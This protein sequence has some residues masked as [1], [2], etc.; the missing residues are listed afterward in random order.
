[1]RYVNLLLKQLHQ[2]SS[3][4]GSGV[5]KKALNIEAWY[6]YATFDLVGDLVFGQSFGCLEGS[7]YH[8][9]GMYEGGEKISVFD[10]TPPRR[11]LLLE[12][13][14]NPKFLFCSVAVANLLVVRTRLFFFVMSLDMFYGLRWFSKVSLGFKV[15]HADMQVDLFHLQVGALGRMARLPLLR[16][17]QRGRPVDMEVQ[18]FPPL[19]EDAGLHQRDAGVAPQLG[20]GAP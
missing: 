4:S 10:E 19:R 18:Q 13:C 20:Q 8:P 11:L 9:W 16:R 12:A 14:R 17:P 5:E 6:N 2:E 7:D 1:M 3:N 15:R